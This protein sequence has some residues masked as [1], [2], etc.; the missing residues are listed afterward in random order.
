LH[1]Q[2]CHIN[3]LELQAVFNA[4]HHFRPFVSGK[5][6]LVRLDNSTVVAYINR[7][8]MCSPRLCLLTRDLYL[9]AWDNHISLQAVHIPGVDNSIADA[10]SRG[11]IRLT[12]WSLHRGVS[13]HLFA[14][15]P[16]PNIDLFASAENAQLPV[17]CT[18]FHDP[19]AWAL[20]TPSP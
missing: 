14:E 4:L 19:R 5:H 1:F 13:E 6:V 10:P 11:K 7:Q 9:W 20:D 3:V 15:I 2:G 16:K 18:T 17:F 8:G 12:E